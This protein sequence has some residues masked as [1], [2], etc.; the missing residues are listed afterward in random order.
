MPDV[1]R[2]GSQVDMSDLSHHSTSRMLNW[3]IAAEGDGL[4]HVVNS[5]KPY[6]KPALDF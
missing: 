1:G 4:C 2:K 6:V 3:L 5:H